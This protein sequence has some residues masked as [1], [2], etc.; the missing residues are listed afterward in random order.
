MSRYPELP[1]HTDFGGMTP[2]EQYRTLQQYSA[3]LSN[4]LDLTDARIRDNPRLP[5]SGGDTSQVLTKSTD[6]DYIME[7]STPSGGSSVS[8]FPIWAEENSTLVA[9]TYEWAYGNGANT[10]AGAGIVIPFACE[11]HYMTL[12]INNASAVAEVQLVHN[13]TPNAT[14]TVACATASTG[15]A[16]YTATP[17]SISAGDLVNFRT[18]SATT[19]TAPAQVC[20]WFKVTA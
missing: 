14:Y 20:A 7:W 12:A 2:E 19:T 6:A 16:D 8:W 11:L 10:P 9:T 3:M 17:L 4:E 18:L 5:P 15:T 13:Q 1:T